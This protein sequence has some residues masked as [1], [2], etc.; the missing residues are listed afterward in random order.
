MVFLFE[1]LPLEDD[2]LR[3]ESDESADFL[4]RQ[5]LQVYTNLGYKPISV[6]VLTVEQRVKFVIQ[7]LE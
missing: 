5:L 2:S 3:V 7:R 1:R 4:H 6:P